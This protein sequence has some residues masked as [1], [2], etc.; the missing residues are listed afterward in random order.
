[1]FHSFVRLI[2]NAFEIGS[3]HND[4]RH[5][6]LEDL[7]AMSDDERCEYLKTKSRQLA[8]AEYG[9]YDVFDGAGF[10]MHENL[11]FLCRYFGFTIVLTSEDGEPVFNRRV[12]PNGRKSVQNLMEGKDTTL[13]GR[14][15]KLE[16]WKFGLREDEVSEV[17]QRMKSCPQT[18]GYMICER[19]AQDPLLPLFFEPFAENNEDDSCW[20]FDYWRRETVQTV[21]QDRPSPDLFL[22]SSVA[23][24]GDINFD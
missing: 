22:L 13:Q 12:L 1:M 14:P 16:M 3:W 6:E 18:I 5:D 7:R 15:D 4:R 9:S 21:E 10:G 23:I 19:A 24:A 2:L 11:H 17:L 20:H 8:A